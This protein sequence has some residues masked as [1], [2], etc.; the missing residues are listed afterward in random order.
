MVHGSW[1]RWGSESVALFG[2]EPWP[3]NIRLIDGIIRL[4][5][6]IIWL[7]DPESIND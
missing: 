2:R 1:P 5:H 7:I 4:I 3:I 6:G